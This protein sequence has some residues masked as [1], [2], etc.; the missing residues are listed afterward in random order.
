MSDGIRPARS[1]GARGDRDQHGAAGAVTVPEA[2]EPRIAPRIGPAAVADNHHVGV[3]LV[4][5]EQPE[6]TWP[7]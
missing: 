5:S 3:D 2:T 1:V 6:L 4:R 7:G